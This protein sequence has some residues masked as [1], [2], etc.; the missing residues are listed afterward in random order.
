MNGAD[1]DNPLDQKPDISDVIN[2][3]ADSVLPPKVSPYDIPLDELLADEANPLTPEDIKKLKQIG[4][5]LFA[6]LLGVVLLSVY[7]CQPQKASMAYGICSTFLE[8][9]TPYPHTL[10]HVALEGS[11]TAVR[12]YF[13]S[14]DPFGQFKQETMECKFGPDERMGMKLTE[15][16]R[17]RRP[18]DAALVNEFNQTLPIIMASDPY[19][20]MPGADWKNP[21][22]DH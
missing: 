7:G 4:A 5:G 9:H 10:R 17:N 16:L 11:R 13:T 3:T 12:I 6:A 1:R 8:L 18:V 14:T 19:L 20:A 2:D 21:L 15:I 22:L